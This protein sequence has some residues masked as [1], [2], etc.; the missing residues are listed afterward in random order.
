MRYFLF[1]VCVSIQLFSQNIIVTDSPKINITPFIQYYFDHDSNYDQQ[2]IRA[3][4]FSDSNRTKLMF[5]YEYDSTLWIKFTLTNP[6]DSTI[7]KI[8]EYDY[9][10]LK[11]FE[12]R[13]IQSGKSYR[14][15]YAHATKEKITLNDPIELHIPPHASKTFLLK[16]N[17]TEVALIAKLFLWE[18][19]AYKQNEMRRQHILLF[20]FG[21][22]SGLFLYNLFLFFMT[23]DS[24][25]FFYS[26]SMA[27]F[28][29]MELFLSG[30]FMLLHIGYTL[31][32][33]HLDILLYILGITLPMFTATFLRLRTVWPSL[34]RP[35]VFILVTSTLVMLLSVTYIIPTSVQRIYSLSFFA[36]IVGIGFYATKHIA[37]AKYYLFGWSM[38]LF[39]SV[40]V[41]LNQMGMADWLDQFPFINKIT[42]FSDA[43]IFSMAL[44]ARIRSLQRE[45]DQAV[46]NL[47]EQKNREG[48]RLEKRVQERTEELE[49][50]LKDKQL[51]LQEVHH[52][53]KNN[54]Q[55]IISLLRLQADESQNEILEQIL[56]ESENRVR[57]ISGV[58]EM[59][60][61]NDSLQQIDTQT[62]FQNLCNDIQNVYDLRHKITVS[63]DAKP[64]LPMDK[65]IYC[66][67]I[68]NELVTNAYKYAFG[69]HGGN[70]TISLAYENEYRLTISDDGIGMRSKTKEGL[71]M[72]LVKTLV[73]KQLKG[74]VQIDTLK[75]TIFTIRFGGET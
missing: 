7:I 31:Y 64:S 47:F 69:D 19:D 13:D 61:Q 63:I 71:G 16:S 70:V 8:F 12:L 65:A 22:M 55:M 20:F 5:G 26:A 66:G 67:L 62:Y 18:R 52:R 39:S 36:V 38:L 30:Y 49:T 27:A 10:I 17:S 42:I 73:T 3:I 46:H 4:H 28:T 32:K 44:S 33:W 24:A 6:T 14:G 56:T 68:L 34:Y 23:R 51:L 29:A 57:A 25:Y 2:S 9:P 53:V 41:G 40:L 1:L 59:L 48:I 60:Y 50:A 35:I 54:L 15:G 21:G 11:S 43:L 37:Q 72:M 45:K 58:H 74:T 75:G